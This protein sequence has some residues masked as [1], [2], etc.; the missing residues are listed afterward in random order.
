M[1]S[2]ACETQRRGIFRRDLRSSPALH[3][4]EARPGL[5]FGCGSPEVPHD[6]PES[7]TPARAA[8]RLTGTERH[9]F[10]RKSEDERCAASRLGFQVDRALVLLDDHRVCQSETLPGSLAD[11][12]G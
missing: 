1:D 6:I 4:R 12:L 5:A 2:P 10:Q 7:S 11:W 8:I 3:S 9:S